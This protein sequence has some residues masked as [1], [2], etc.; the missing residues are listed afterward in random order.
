MRMKG[1]QA[2]FLEF[3]EGW[4]LCQEGKMLQAFLSVFD[5]W[6]PRQCLPAAG[7][8]FSEFL[9]RDSADTCHFVL[10]PDVP[11]ATAL[12]LLGQNLPEE[13]LDQLRPVALTTCTTL[14]SQPP[15]PEEASLEVD[16]M[17]ALPLP[18]TQ[19]NSE[20]GVSIMFVVGRTA[21]YFL[22][23]ASPFFL[24]ELSQVMG[25]D[26]WGASCFFEEDRWYNL[27][28]FRVEDRTDLQGSVAF[29]IVDPFS[30]QPFAVSL[31]Q[32]QCF[33]VRGRAMPPRLR[34]SGEATLELCST[35][36]VPAFLASGWAVHLLPGL[37]EVQGLQADI[38]FAPRRNRL[39][40]LEHD[41]LF[42]CHKLLL[43]GLLRAIEAHL[44]GDVE[45]VRV[46]VQLEG[47]T[48]WLGSLPHDLSFEDLADLWEQAGLAV[49]SVC[50]VRVYSGPKA[51]PSALT[52]GSARCGP[53]HPGFVSTGGFLLL[54]FMPET[55]GGGAKDDKFR[56]TQTELAQLFLD[57][58]LALS[59]TTTAVD[60]L[61]SQAGASRVQRALDLTDGTNRWGQVQALCQQ[62]S[63]TLPARPT[64]A[65]KA[66]DVV[67]QEAVKR[68]AR[69]GPK[70]CAADFQIAPGF[71]RNADDSEAA[72]LSKLVPGASGVLLCD[73]ADAPRL[74]STWSGQSQD[75][76][77]LVILGHT[78]PD[79]PSCQGHCGVPAHTAAGE[80]VIVHACW[81]NLGASPLHVRCTNDASVALPEDVCVCLSVFQD[82]T[83]VADWETFKANPVRA[84]ADNL[85]NSGF[86]AR[87]DAPYGRSFRAAGRPC[88]PEECTSV[89]FHCRIPSSELLPLL[90]LSGHAQIYVTPK[91]WKNEVLPGFAVIW[92]QGDKADVINMSLKV[93]DPLGLV[94]AKNRLGIRVSEA[95]Y[96]A[97]WAIVRPDQEVP[98]KV[99]VNGLYKLLSAPPQLRA[100]DIQTWAS[101]MNWQVRPLRCL[102]P[103]Q[104]LLGAHGPPPPGLLSMNKQAVLVQ[105]VE[106]RQ[107]A[108]PI[109]RAGRL[110]KQAPRA[111]APTDE[112][113]LVAN[114]P[115]KQYL[116]HQSG[117]PASG[118]PAA[119]AQ[120]PARSP[121]P[122]NQQRF[123]Q[124]ESRLQ[125]LEAGLAEV[126]RG[127]CA[128]SQQLA[129]TQVAVEAQVD[130]VKVDLASFAA[131]FR[132]QMQANAAAQR[133]SQSAHEQQFQRG[134]DEIKALLAGP[135]ARGSTPSKRPA[136][137]EG[138]PPM[139]LDPTL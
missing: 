2:R 51:V 119:S 126:R 83:R 27:E 80:G 8:G 133:A 108:K 99:E 61:M 3:A 75:E 77:G 135:G 82:E 113:P 86:K 138:H 20:N 4:V 34:I 33:Q 132:T 115:W 19:F 10:A 89:Q 15:L 96:K 91:S 136:T 54:S 117:Q 30:V 31:D 25:F 125:Q 100:A 79:G 18:V 137:T 56:N 5:M 127:H 7:L 48:L 41:V 134:L 9:L 22:N 11:V 110:P 109:L 60:R 64:R 47:R 32:L 70:P 123:D 24:W 122:P 43:V 46:K 112:D 90:R 14:A 81:H 102:G 13:C 87:L 44:E 1:S 68:Q 16:I 74:L 53:L 71:F 130:Q 92:M 21:Y 78:C 28:G 69:Q 52:L 12:R 29:R 37:S 93:P 39:R 38:I 95:N 6:R 107:A 42:S 88:S 106:A 98:P 73:S 57:K 85:R 116:N 62:F 124:Q 139:E 129:H 23:R 66:A 55:R 17:P 128:M 49:Q 97:A 111:T 67:Q 105:P 65:S 45:P 94:R 50:P 114:D 104:W 63:V 59:Q 40:V 101:H 36:P 120:A 58:G 131:D 35:F 103:G 76:L 118:A 72:V 84:V 26:G 121:A